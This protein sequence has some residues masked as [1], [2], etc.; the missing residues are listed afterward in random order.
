MPHIPVLL[1]EVIKILDPSRGEFFIDATAGRGGHTEKILE[2]I[3]ENGKILAIDWDEDNTSFL[4][5]KFVDY[6]NVL[7]EHANYTD[8]PEILRQKKLPR[9]DGL[10]LDLGFSSN[11]LAES[12]RGFSFLKDE[13]LLMTYDQ[14]QTPVKDL[15]RKMSETELAEALRDFGEEK[16]AKQIARAVRGA[17]KPIE[18]TG[19]LARIVKN[20]VPKNYERGHRRGGASRLN[21]ATRTFQALRIYA[22]SELGNL[23]KL[24][25]N[26]TGILK[27]GGRAAI[28]S[29][30]SLEDRIVKNYFKAMEKEAK[31]KILTKKPVGPTFLEVKNNPRSRSAKLRA[32][33]FV[34]T[35]VR[36]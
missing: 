18:T 14:N 28:I 26:L 34:Q 5:K 29:F 10:L 19:E 27:S 16:F 7:V 24:L 30:H 11:Q 17:K 31:L 36:N 21:P 2:R 33:V 20:A 9:A 22:N 35:K 3:G 25:N 1:E 15:I 13:P 6:P 12:G 8:T 32:A 23:E 4:K